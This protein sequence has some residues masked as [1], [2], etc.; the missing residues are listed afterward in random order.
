M[1]ITNLASV[2][3]I[4]W[5]ILQHQG[6]DAEEV[7]RKVGLNPA[8][9]SKP[10]R[11]YKV[12]KTNMLW[13]EAAKWINDPCFGLTAAQHWHP[14]YLGTLGYTM[15]AST[16]LR[17]ALERLIRFH[18]VVTDHQF[19]ALQENK[20]EKTFV[21]T[22]LDLQSDVALPCL[23]DA[24]LALIISILRMNY[25]QELNPVRVTLQHPSPD[26]NSRYFELFRC[27]VEF[28]APV[29][30]M[31]LPLDAVDKRLPGSNLELTVAGEHLMTDYINS[32]KD[33]LLTT[34]IK[35][36]IAQHL[37]T[38][39]ANVETVA[40]RLYVS[41][42]TLQRHLKNEKTS[43]LRLL[44]ETRTELAKA[45]VR[46]QD[47]DLTEVAFLLGFSELSTFSRSFKKWTGLA[48]AHYRQ[49]G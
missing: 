43:F 13:Q 2:Q 14:S 20:K 1:Q 40:D 45:Y 37:P 36:I 44:T 3:H 8:L 33:P 27:P 48:P 47:M 6:E 32:L 35:K 19:A 4:L 41:T 46:D 42:R 7:F 16:T 11:R 5:N 31:A 22:L 25:Q 24:V 49:T 30:S 21:I 9:M 17:A 39:D 34:R 38:G 18:R 26:C 10:G 28:E 15:L 12:E 29:T 23:E